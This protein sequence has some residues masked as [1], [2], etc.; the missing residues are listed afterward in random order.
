MHDWEYWRGGRYSSLDQK[1]GL[2]KILHEV[3]THIITISN[4]YTG[5]PTRLSLYD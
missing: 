4:E 5:L 3:T 1:Q 2:P